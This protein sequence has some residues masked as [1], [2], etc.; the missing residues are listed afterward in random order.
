MRARRHARLRLGVKDRFSHLCG[1]YEY[2]LREHELDIETLRQ[3][4]LP[5]L[6]EH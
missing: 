2:L 4:L 5:L 1:S 6:S 3:R